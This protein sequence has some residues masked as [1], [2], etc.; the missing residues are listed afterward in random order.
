MMGRFLVWLMLVVF[1]ADQTLALA[2]PAYRIGVLATRSKATAVAA[3]QPM[4]DYLKRAMYGLHF[5]LVSL[6]AAELAEAVAG[7]RVDFILTSPEQ[8]V[9]MQSRYRVSAI[10]SLVRIRGGVGLRETGGIILVRSDRAD[11]V[12]LGDLRGKSIATAER[13][14]L[15][16][17]LAQAGELAEAGIDIR[18]DSKLET[19]LTPDQ[20]TQA[21]ASGQADAGFLPAGVIEALVS[22]GR[23]RPNSFRVLNLQKHEGFPFMVST[24]LYP[25][26]SF[27]SMP[28]IPEPL[29]KQVAT[30]L[31]AMR[32]D[33]APPWQGSA[34][35]WTLPLGLE[36][37]HRLLH[38]L[39]LPPYEK[40]DQFDLR[41]VLR[42][43]ELEAFALL[44]IALALLFVVVV[45][46]RRL[47]HQLAGQM[48]LAYQR[49]QELE[50]EIG[51]RQQAENRLAG[52]NAIL[53]TLAAASPLSTVLERLI[54]M[55]ER[56][57]P[58]KP[59]IVLLFAAE[60]RRYSI[61]A[62]SNIDA[63][64]MRD[65]ENAATIIVAADGSPGPGMSKLCKRCGNMLAEP[66]LSDSGA[67]LGCLLIA[68]PSS[69]GERE[70]VHGMVSLAAVSI[71]RADAASRLRLNASVFENAIEGVM[72]A[73]PAGTI[74]D[75]NTAFTRL[76]GYGRAEAIGKNPRFL[77]SGR[78]DID[79][80]VAMWASLAETGGWLGEIWNRRKDGEVVVEMLRIAAI[81]DAAGQVTHYVGTFSDITVL[82]ETQARLNRAI[83]G[84]T[85]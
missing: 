79:F 16:G 4:V 78:H 60:Q 52:A 28:H 32:A 15:T 7:R 83:Y 13:D 53:D 45:R 3:F 82:K 35:E 72:I 71:Q 59:V 75:I 73:D 57:R 11:L 33:D 19:D 9:D 30:S 20:V 80:Y 43:Y 1:A 27:A 40:A 38:S 63:D 51:V 17:Y 5:E 81:R 66:V 24:R 36:S 69:A 68:S 47:N 55:H 54:G 77:K 70:L 25:D 12:N 39:R 29:A 34:I 23:A 41:D 46:F 76:T 74:V 21:V 14:H 2:E 48:M 49:R 58:G 26:W 64:F 50:E 65:I 10:A 85:N 42:K 44:A 37:V 67:R 61:A 8:L 56:E 84:T 22:E 6:G 18:G 31:L 62:H